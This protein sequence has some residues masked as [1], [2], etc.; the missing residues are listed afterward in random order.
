MGEGRAGPAG[1]GLQLRGCSHAF[2]S[3]SERPSGC[4]VFCLSILWPPTAGSCPV[5]VTCEALQ[6]STGTQSG[7]FT[8]RFIRLV[9]RIQVTPQ[10]FCLCFSRSF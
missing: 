8:F 5:Q 9:G 7:S 4:F 3:G 1:G 6:R 10:E 2:A